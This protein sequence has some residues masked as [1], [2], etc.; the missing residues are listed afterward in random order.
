MNGDSL[1]WIWEDLRSPDVND[2][3]GDDPPLSDD[4]ADDD[5]PMY[6]GDGDDRSEV[7]SGMSFGDSLLVGDPNALRQL[8]AVVEDVKRQYYYAGAPV[9]D[10]DDDRIESC[11]T[12][13]DDE[14]RDCDGTDASDDALYVDAL[15]A[16]QSKLSGV[17]LAWTD[18]LYNCTVNG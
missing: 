10:D 1:D 11:E 4:D 9:D 3:S 13:R 7:G 18:T 15:R 5:R 14:A 12:E 6:G 17:R 8:N 16:V 2:G